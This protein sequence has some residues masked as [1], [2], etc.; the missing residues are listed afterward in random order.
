MGANKRYKTLGLV[1]LCKHIESHKCLYR[2]YI[3]SPC[4][5]TFHTAKRKTP[6]KRY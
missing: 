6:N 1:R 2:G 3:R 4:S 5:P